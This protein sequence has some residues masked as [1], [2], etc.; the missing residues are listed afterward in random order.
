MCGSW[1]VTKPVGIHLHRDSAPGSSHLGV[2]DSWTSW[3]TGLV[4]S[5]H[6]T[7]F[8]PSAPTKSALYSLYK[9]PCVF[10]AITSRFSSFFWVKGWKNNNHQNVILLQVLLVCGLTFWNRASPLFRRSRCDLTSAVITRREAITGPLSDSDSK[11][12]IS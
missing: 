7:P 9:C 12:H 10:Y 5:E 3:C 1:E 8:F 4:Q 2:E 6:L 11:N